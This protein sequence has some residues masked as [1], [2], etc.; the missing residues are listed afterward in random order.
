MYA[1]TTSWGNFHKSESVQTLCIC[2][3][4]GHPYLKM[5]VKSQNKLRERN[6][7]RNE[8]GMSGH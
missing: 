6:E 4:N 8:L 5:W 3:Q 1:S 2:V 7:L